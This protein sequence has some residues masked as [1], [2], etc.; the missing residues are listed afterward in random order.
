MYTSYPFHLDSISHPVSQLTS[1][2]VF[3]LC[4]R[5]TF[6]LFKCLVVFLYFFIF[7]LWSLLADIYTMH[8]RAFVSTTRSLHSQFGLIFW[9]FTVPA[10]KAHYKS[11]VNHCRVQ[12]LCN[13]CLRRLCTSKKHV[14]QNCWPQILFL[15]LSCIH[16]HSLPGGFPFGACLA[17]LCVTAV[18]IFALTRYLYMHWRVCFYFLLFEFWMLLL[19]LFMQPSGIRA[20]TP[21]HICAALC[22]LTGI[23][24]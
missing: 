17:R 2:W 23:C 12:R 9:W 4:W 8:V 7:L 5:L 14:H 20:D 16:W 13:D 22:I 24:F 18:Y 21:Q 15:P 10:V 6:A 19:S 11:P 1:Q 3:F